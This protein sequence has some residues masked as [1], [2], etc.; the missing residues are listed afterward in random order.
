[1][2]I[3]KHKKASIHKNG[4]KVPKTALSEDRSE[5]TLSVC[6]DH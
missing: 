6:F 2:K 3:G 1:M 4:E 5:K